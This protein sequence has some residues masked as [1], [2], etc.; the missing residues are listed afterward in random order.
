MM[1]QSSVISGQR[2]G[3]LRKAAADACVIWSGA[4]NPRGVARALVAAIDAA[5]DLRS[6]GDCAPDELALAP[7]RVILAQLCFLLNV[8]PDGT[9][10]YAAGSSVTVFVS[11]GPIVRNSEELQARFCRDAAD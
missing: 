11:V 7:A 9:G 6:G 5:C 3:A 2:V 4:S 8:A 1:Q 10:G